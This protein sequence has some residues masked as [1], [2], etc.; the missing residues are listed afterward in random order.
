MRL[1]LP[2]RNEVKKRLGRAAAIQAV[3]AMALTGCGVG[4]PQAAS[5]EPT[6]PPTPVIPTPEAPTPAPTPA[7]LEVDPA[8]YN[9]AVRIFQNAL[10]DN[11]PSIYLNA[12]SRNREG[13][14]YVAGEIP[15]DA[16]VVVEYKVQT[17]QGLVTARLFP[18]VGRYTISH[19]STGKAASISVSLVPAINIELDNLRASFRSGDVS[20]SISLNWEL[21]LSAIFTTDPVENSIRLV[22]P[23]VLKDEEAELNGT[24]HSEMYEGA[25]TDEPWTINSDGTAATR[26]LNPTYLTD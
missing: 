23:K 19:D 16:E 7:R 17:P 12:N 1:E 14:Q 2:R 13:V 10:I 21:L 20:P 22:S 3:T 8:Q 6:V 4:E 18:D 11:L 26:P 25:L 5:P 15:S 9:E 24:I